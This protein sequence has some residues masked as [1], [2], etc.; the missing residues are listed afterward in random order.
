MHDYPKALEYY[1]KALGIC[2]KI[3][4][5]EHSDIAMSYDYIGLVYYN[6]SDYFESLEYYNKALVIRKKL[7]GEDDSRTA[8]SYVNI[9]LIYRKTGNYPE[10]LAYFNKAWIIYERVYKEKNYFTKELEE[11]IES[12]SKEHH[13]DTKAGE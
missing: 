8:A 7:Y 6:L 4:G 10:A 12:L 2:K 11:I 3:Y 1:N 9:G 5:E 13:S